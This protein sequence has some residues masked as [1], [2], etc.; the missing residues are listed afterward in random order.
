MAILPEL[1]I[2]YNNP[3]VGYTI[4]KLKPFEEERMKCP[5]CQTENPRGAKFCNECGHYLIP[6]AKSIPQFLSFH[7]KLERIQRYLPRGLTQKI[8]TQ[9]DKIE[10]ERKQ[11][12]VMF[13]D[14][15]GFTPLV[16]R[17]GPEKAYSIMDQ[18][19][20]ILI[21]KVYDYEG[22]VNEMTG[23]GIMALF[24]A[25]IAVEEAPQ[26]SLW[27]ALSIHSEIAKFNEQNSE[28]EPIKM[29]I[30][31]HTGPV[32]VGT[33]G[34]DLRVEFKAVGNTVNLA[35][36]MEELAESG[37]TYVTEETFR[38]TEGIFRFEALGEKAI[39][40]KNS[41]I[42]VYK[43]VSGKTDGYRPRLGSERM[44]YSD[45][46]GRDSKLNRLE[47]QVMKVIN[48]EGSVVNIIGEAGIGKSRL[49]AELKKREVMKKVKILE[50]RAISIGRNLSF[51]PIIGIFKQWAQIMEDDREAM[52]LGKLEAAVSRLIP[53]ELGE[54]LPFVAV[55]MGMKLSGRYA[56]RVKG[57]EGEALEKLI[58][59][60]V[61]KLLIKVTEQT[62]LVIIVEDL[63]WADTSSI[64]LMESLFRLAE[65]KRVLFINIFRPGIQKTSD[66]IIETVKDG[67][68]VYNVEIALEPLDKQMSEVL[69]NNMLNISGVHHAIIDQIVQRAGGNPFF[70]EEVVRSFIDENAVVLK[71]RTF[72]VTRKIERIAIPTTL[73]DVLMARIDRLDEVTR[74][75][76]KFAS[77]IGRYF[78]YRIL[79][80]V[81]STVEDIDERLSH[82]KEVQLVQER[83]R[84]GE[85][86]YLFKHTLAQ[87]AVYES[88]LPQKRKELHLK[89]ADSIE[90]IFSERLHE[91][92]GML[93]YHYSKAESPEK[94]E[95]YLIKA[96]EEALRS[97]ASNEAL[98]YYQKALGLYL[99]KYGDKAD[100]EKVA[101][102][103]KN[104]A[105]AL[106]NRG[107]Y[108]EAVEYFEKALD[109]HWRKLPKH[110]TLA[111]IMFLSAFFQFIIALYF[112]YLKFRKIPTQSDNEIVDLFFKK[113][114]SL[115]IINQKRFFIESF[116]F[117]KIVTGFNLQKFELGIGLFVGAS[118]LF[119]FTGISFRLSRK[120]LDFAKG[121]VFKGQA[122][123]FIIYE[124][125]EVL[126]NYS[127]GNWKAID[128]YDED[129]VNKNLSLGEIWNVSQHLYW[130]GLSNIYQGSLDSALSM[131]DKLNNI[132]EEYE[133]DFS[134]LLKYELNTNVLLEYRK[135]SDALIEVEKA[136]GFA[137]SADLPLF[138]FDLYSFKLWI[139]ILMGNTEE[140]EKSLQQA[141]KMRS[142][143]HAV[144]VMLSTFHL[145]QFQ[146]FLNRLEEPIS[147]SSQ[148][149]LLHYRQE[150]I[151]TC[152]MLLKV[153]R[154]TAQH[155]TE[156]YKLI[157]V[158]YW[159]I[160]KQRK[161]LKWWQK[162]IDEGQRLGADLELSRT[163]FEVGK[164][165]LES[166]SQDKMPNGIKAEGYLKRARALFTKI[167]L[168]WD[169]DELD[170]VTRI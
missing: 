2:P 78:F 145:C 43:V 142:R 87:E 122:K 76:V 147:S 13:C 57:I 109:H 150:I 153:L 19:Y 135:L 144:P 41:A 73:N 90:K 88:I 157:G 89:V 54:V 23:D 164:R 14:M 68:T 123:I 124:L 60:S 137:Q 64:E 120:I 84:M 91:F 143:I 50:G 99:K 139:H 152:K 127:E 82:L 38:L 141:N 26:R 36:R 115:A 114:K 117:F 116:H 66:R 20:E 93:A 156:S 151:A 29:R 75:L 3:D 83:R 85:V 37:S 100:P 46:I 129:L 162:A 27:S 40:G 44:I 132:V 105:H 58:L 25:P 163:Y 18:I 118:T 170:R 56:E 8:L 126:H 133:N 52:A 12:T 136:I 67:L 96:G 35:S 49:V 148:S 138:L 168:Q 22:T 31:V 48:G 161:A 11:V 69:I 149:G 63:Q 166:G 97:S 92:Y 51:H 121:R 59:K 165:L 45:M 160:D 154:K 72:Q 28:I 16:E 42:P 108:V 17:L 65:T 104:I 98:H 71:D 107:Q 80:E 74:N 4:Q 39:R 21:H 15:E 103:E 9:K 159:M 55:L 61:R 62:P 102:L 155:R 106:Y 131:V 6:L 10:G 112:P 1:C 24:G 95:E 128:N 119:S 33:L 167:G 125:S 77:V 110:E 111:F 47:L 34:N 94:S 5:Q 53:E 158:Y 30:G 79:L 7:E 113:L 146:Y 140:A 134:L 32:V 169:L 101:M 130:H 70:I 81:A 86:E